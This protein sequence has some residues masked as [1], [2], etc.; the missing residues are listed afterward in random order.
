MMW[1]FIFLTTALLGST[2]L[3]AG[4]FGP[5]NEAHPPF[6]R[7][8]SYYDVPSVT[9][10][11][12]HNQHIQFDTVL[13]DANPVL[14]EFFFTTCT[15]FCDLRSVRLAAIQHELA[16][17]NIPITFFSI[18]VDPEFDR[19]ERLQAYAT[20][21][22]PIPTN[23]WL[24]TGTMSNIERVETSFKARNPSADKMLHQPITFI[25]GRPGQKWIR[26]EGMLSS[27][28][29]TKQIKIAVVSTSP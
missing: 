16:E 18:S 20:R 4:D 7:T 1:L 13:A 9:L 5:Y 17:A 2:H 15:T 28:E 3:S 21:V 22:K 10:I 27:H 12:Q 8:V 26:L 14:V 23:W 29:L 25:R 24:L 6:T 11:D 19:P